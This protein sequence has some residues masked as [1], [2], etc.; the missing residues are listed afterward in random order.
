MERASITDESGRP[1]DLEASLSRQAA[2]VPQTPETV[3]TPVMAGDVEPTADA[4]AVAD[5]AADADLR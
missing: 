2:G 1:V 3:P 4:E 5:E